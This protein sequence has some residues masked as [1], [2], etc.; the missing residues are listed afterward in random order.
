[1]TKEIEDLQARIAFQEDTISTLN[2][3]VTTLDGEVR[4]LQKQLHLLY[5]KMNDM[6]YQLEQSQGP[7]DSSHDE[8]PPHY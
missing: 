4:D 1:M 7:A 2:R 3:Q 6:V 5:K 8:R